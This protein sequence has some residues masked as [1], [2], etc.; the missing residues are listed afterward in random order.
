MVLYTIR[1]KMLDDVTPGEPCHCRVKVVFGLPCRHSLPRDHVLTLV[2]IPESITIKE[3]TPWMKSVSWLEKLFRCCED[4]QQVRGL[5]A[6]VNNFIENAKQY[7]DHPEM[8]FSVASEVKAPGRS[9]HIKRKSALPKDYVLHKH[10]YLLAQKSK[11]EIRE[12]IKQE[13]RDA[14]KECLEEEPLKKSIK[15]IKKEKEFTKEQEPLKEG[16][17]VLSIAKTNNIADKQELLKEAEKHFFGIKRLNHLP[18][19]YC[20]KTNVHDFALPI[21]IDQSAVSLTFNPKS[22]E[23]GENQFPLVKKKMLETVVTHVT[24]YEQNFEMD[25]AEVTKDIA[26][27]SERTIGASCL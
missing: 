22:D 3:S 16:I 20:K 21:Q 2:N 15:K 14:V 1:A 25:I 10:R 18:D 4:E 9:K 11:D 13:L 23:G 6:K 8:V 12:M 19:D 26:H 17:Y 27:G 24:L 7:L 5:M